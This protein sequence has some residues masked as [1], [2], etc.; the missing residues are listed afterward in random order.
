MRTLNQDSITEKN[1][2]T[3]APVW[4]YEFDIDGTLFRCAEH[5]E[6]IEYP[7]GSGTVFN[8]F[9]I[10]HGGV[11]TSSDQSIDSIRL[12]VSNISRELISYIRDTDGM[13]N[14]RVK[15]YQVF[16]DALDDPI[17]TAEEE[18]FVSRLSYTEDVITVTVKSWFDILQHKLPGRVITRADFPFIPT[19]VIGIG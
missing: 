6:N 2:E 17:P 18:M 4:L 11:K 12:S 14:Q 9:P 13:T 10:S 7:A 15:I 3:N 5:V 19:R 8:A 16:L 1:A